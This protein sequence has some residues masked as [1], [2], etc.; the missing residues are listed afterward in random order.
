MAKLEEWIANRNLSGWKNSIRVRGMLEGD[1]ENG[2]MFRMEIPEVRDL[3][4][5]EQ[6]RTKR[7]ENEQE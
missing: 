6:R 7:V 3:P 5:E 1:I 4:E 2:E